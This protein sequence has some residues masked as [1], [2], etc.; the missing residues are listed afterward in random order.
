MKK[1]ILGITGGVGCG[2]S[3]VLE[4]LEKD[5]HAYVIQ[6]DH[7]A[8][9]LMAPGGASYE[10]IVEAF[11]TGI[12]L[13]ED[14]QNDRQKDSKPAIDR[15]ALG[16]IVFHD[17]EQLR[18]LNRLTHPEVKKEIRRRVAESKDSFVVIE[19][20]LLLEEHYEE[21]CHE[22]WYIY[23]DQE[24][25]LQRLEAARGYSREKSLSMMGTQKSEG[26]FRTA[27]QE[28]IDN[29]GFLEETKRQLDEKLKKRGISL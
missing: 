4:I 12:L 6:A 28:T 24:T 15:K 26:E 21:I 18:L 23:A 8:H 13:V 16:A 3:A 17:E 11:G 5:Y 1:W 27:C 10:K 25:R 14:G 29:S 22:I 2:K 9:D 19:A 20:A 7:V